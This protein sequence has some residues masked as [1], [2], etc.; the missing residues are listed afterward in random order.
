[1]EENEE[2]AHVCGRKG[3]NFHFRERKWINVVEDKKESAYEQLF[4]IDDE[5]HSYWKQLLFEAFL[6]ARQGGLARVDLMKAFM[7]EMKHPG[8]VIELLKIFDP[9]EETCWTNLHRQ[10]SE[11]NKVHSNTF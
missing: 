6:A 9:W 2:V 1:M 7:E 3:R 11:K 8:H 10:I 4:K 5:A